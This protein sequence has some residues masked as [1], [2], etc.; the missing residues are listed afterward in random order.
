MPASSDVLLARMLARSRLRQWQ[1][2]QE[3]AAL[4]SVQRAADAIGKSQP[5]ATHALSELER[6][7]G[8]ALFERH[9][10]GARLTSAG[11]AVL[12]TVRTAMAA[13]ADC[14]GAMSDLLSGSQG[15]VRIGAIEAAIG[16]LLGDAVARFTQT[17]PAVAVKVVNQAPDRLLQ[18]LSDGVIDLVV[19]RRPGQLPAATVFEALRSDRYSIVCSPS[20]PLAGRHGVTRDQLARHLWLAAPKASIAEG[21]FQAFWDGTTPPRMLCWVESRALTLTFAMI[22]QRQALVLIPRNIVQPWL[23]NGVLAEVP[24]TWGLSIEPVGALFRESVLSERG[25]AR[26]FLEVLRRLRDLPPQDSAGV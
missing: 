13:F 4:G 6:L 21:D 16:G 3:I 7:L 11:E 24:G 22:E 17:Y 9:A 12:P 25:P 8:F 15:E 26:D 10:K 18:S 20:H 23:S 5:A 2:I 19:A 14:A 1:L